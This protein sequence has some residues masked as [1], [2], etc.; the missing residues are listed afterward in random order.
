MITKMS[1]RVMVILLG[2]HCSLL[3]SSAQEILSLAGSWDL[4]IGDS[5]SYDDYVMLPGSMLTNGKGDK[6]TADTRW[7]GSTYDSSY[8]FNP[9]MEKYRQEDNVKFPFFLTPE[10]H[11]VGKAWY[12]KSVYIPKDWKQQRVTLFLE[13]P[14]IVTFVF[15]NGQYVGYQMSLSAPHQY[16]VT[17]F[18]VP[19]QRN[20]IAICVYN[21]IESD[22]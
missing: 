20:T 22:S 10:K 19:G 8:Y 16:D 14:H 18:I 6:V 5:V 3:T 17:K 1:K 7:T 2:I 12:K 15:V 4:S 21:G 9:W 11:Y 13:R